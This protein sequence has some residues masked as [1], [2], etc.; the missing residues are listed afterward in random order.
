MEKKDN[1]LSQFIDIMK[2]GGKINREDLPMVESLIAE[3]PYFTLPAAMAIKEA[4]LDEPTRRRLRCIVAF[5]A[6]D[7]DSLMKLID[8]DGERFAQFYPADPQP[9]TPTTD[10]AL[11]TFL[12]Q[13]GSMDQKEQDLLERLIFNPIPDYSQVLA[14]E[15]ADQPMDEPLS[16]QD[17][18]L[19]AFLASQQS[20]QQKPEP[21]VTPAY[22]N[23]ATPTDADAPLSE[24]L[25]K[26]YVKQGRYD[27]AYEIIY[28]LSLNFPKKSIY[29]ADQ[30]R[31]LKK[32]IAVSQAN[33]KK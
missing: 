13:Y 28:Q 19:D 3:Y 10:K 15:V 7:T 4:D 1:G 16:E 21:T 31:F 22:T 27:K 5:N 33:A 11:D 30:L 29:F 25:A 18:M 17:S 9:E 14:R 20:E 6:T 8:P 2:R 12:D 24:S 32:L 26:I 23:V